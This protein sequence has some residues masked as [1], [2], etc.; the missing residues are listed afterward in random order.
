VKVHNE[1]GINPAL[2]AESPHAAPQY[3]RSTGSPAPPLAITPS[4]A[5]QRFLDVATVDRQ[6]LKPTLS[7]L[8]LEYRIVQLYSRD[9]GRREAKLS[10][11]IGQGTQDIGF[12]N[13]VPIL[14]DC[15]PAVEVVLG[16]KDADGRPAM[17]SFLV[18]DSAG[19]VMPNPARRLAPDFFFHPQVYRADGESLLLPPGEYVVEVGRGPEHV[20]ET[21][22]LTV[23]SGVVSHR[24]AFE[25]KRW[26]HPLARGWVSGDHHVHAAGCAHYENPTE[27]VTPGDMMRHILGED[28]NVGCVLSWGPAGTRRSSSSRGR[29]RPCQSPGT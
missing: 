28:L 17:A 8:E 14:F 15:V 5:A 3:K 18:R 25:L 21:R 6:P 23:P 2:V 27:G 19:R 16:V 11:H 7:G 20:F 10:F 1:A 29:P 9:V 26:I 24:A 13:A 4:D 12:R 22:K